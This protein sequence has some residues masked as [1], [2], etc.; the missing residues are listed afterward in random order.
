MSSITP[1]F[2][3]ASGSRRR[4]ELLREAGYEFEVMAPDESVE[5]GLCSNCS[6]AE[7]VRDLAL[8]KGAHVAERLAAT[9]PDTPWLLLAADTVAECGGQILGKPD[10]EEHARQMLRLMRGKRHRVLSGICVW[11]SQP[12]AGEPTGTRLP[13]VEVVVTELE[14]DNL[15]DEAI[16]QYVDSDQWRGKA[17]GFGYQDRLGWIRVVEGSESNVVGL[18]M[19]RV[20]RVL[21]QFGV[22]TR[23]PGATRMDVPPSSP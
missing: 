1:R 15:S 16:E 21:A 20:A 10:D 18:P 7:M 4:A 14:M 2:F 6:A 9:W 12:T 22:F 23:A 8:R 11:P 5:Q 19:E 13:H 17:G 3:L